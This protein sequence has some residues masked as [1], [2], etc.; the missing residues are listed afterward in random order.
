MCESKIKGKLYPFGNIVY[1][2]TS[3]FELIWKEKNNE[4]Q[5]PLTIVAKY[6]R[7]DIF[8]ELCNALRN[9]PE[10]KSAIEEAEKILIESY[11]K[12]LSEKY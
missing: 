3:I 6:G 11:E 1:I 9:I 8:R 2:D 12:E 4:G 5:T 10:A 7:G